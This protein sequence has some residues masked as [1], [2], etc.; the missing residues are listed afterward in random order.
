MET[1]RSLVHLSL[2]VRLTPLVQPS[3]VAYPLSTQ[4]L[5]NQLS[6][7]SCCRRTSILA[8]YR[9][10]WQNRIFVKT[11]I[12]RANIDRLAIP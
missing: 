10:G 1:A 8:Q 7:R 4:R 5:R 11:T 2:R 3:K 12:G 9:R 6:P